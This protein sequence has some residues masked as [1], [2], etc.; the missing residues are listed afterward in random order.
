M[1]HLWLPI[2]RSLW[3]IYITGLNAPGR[4]PGPGRLFYGERRLRSVRLRYSLPSP[5][6]IAGTPSFKPCVVG[7]STQG[8]DAGI[9]Q[10]VEQLICNQQ[11][12]GSS[13]SIGSMRGLVQSSPPIIPPFCDLTAW[14]DR[15]PWGRGDAALGTIRRCSSMVEH[16][17]SKQVTRVR[18]PSP[19]PLDPFS[20]F[21]LLS[22]TARKD[23]K[24]CAGATPRGAITRRYTQE[25]KGAPLLRE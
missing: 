20:S 12:G 24:C 15:K 23:G 9:A 14:K 8:T 25:V 11:V 5:S 4:T 22:L 3:G 18:F 2:V 17:P 16:L 13:P 7:H 1:V 19:A 6:G 21:S 10:S